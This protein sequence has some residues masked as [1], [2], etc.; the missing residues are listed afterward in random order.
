MYTFVHVTKTGGT[1]I[2]KYFEKHLSDYIDFSFDH[3]RIC[4]S[5]NNPII[6]IR[7]PIDRFISMYKY[8]IKGSEMYTPRDKSYIVKTRNSTSIKHFIT[9]LKNEKNHKK[10]LYHS[11][12]LW[13]QHYAPTSDWIHTELSN[14]IGII[15]SSNLNN[16]IP[17]KICSLLNLPMPFESLEK[18]NVSLIKYNIKL[19]N[20]DIDFIKD[21]YAKDFE[22]WDIINNNPE[23]FKHVL[24]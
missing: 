24:K 2:A 14:I 1:S 9:F 16:V 10:E 13:K 23:K 22:L 3:D 21:Y 19:D 15:Y 12:F 7:E 18:M 4:L 5:D 6:I 20:D 8:W 17:S 11:Y